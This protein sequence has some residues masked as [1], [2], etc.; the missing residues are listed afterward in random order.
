MKI[1]ATAAT[2]VE[3]RELARAR[4]KCTPWISTVFHSKTPGMKDYVFSDRILG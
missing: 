1:T 3:A 4:M 2:Y